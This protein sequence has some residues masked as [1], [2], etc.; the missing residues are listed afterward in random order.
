MMEHG[1]FLVICTVDIEGDH[2]LTNVRSTG[3]GMDPIDRPGLLQ[4]TLSLGRPKY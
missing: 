2:L 1:V 3:R 4:R